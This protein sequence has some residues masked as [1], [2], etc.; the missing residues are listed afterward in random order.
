M[1]GNIRKYLGEIFH[2][3]A[4]QKE[5]QMLEGHVAVDHVQRK[6]LR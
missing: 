5:S 3:L 2:E 4:R 1:F 6:M